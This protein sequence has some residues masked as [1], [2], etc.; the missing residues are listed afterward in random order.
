MHFVIQKI[1]DFIFVIFGKLSNL[2]WAVLDCRGIIFLI[3]GVGLLIAILAYII[4]EFI[5]IGNGQ[6]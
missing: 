3:F 1:A 4:S 2:L 6:K 5:R